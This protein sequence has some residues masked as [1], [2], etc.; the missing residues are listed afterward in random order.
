M[1]KNNKG[2]RPIVAL[3][4]GSGYNEICRIMLS[5][6][7]SVITIHNRGD[8]NKIRNATHL[9]LS[10]GADIH[11]SYYAQET[12]YARGFDVKRDWLELRLARYAINR[13]MPTLGICRG[14]QMLAV[15]DGGA[16]WQDFAIQCEGGTHAPQHEIRTAK[17]SWIREVLGERCIVNSFHHQAVSGISLP[18]SWRATAWSV[19]DKNNEIIEGMEHKSKPVVGVQFHPEYITNDKNKAGEYLLYSWLDG[20]VPATSNPTQA[21]TLPLFA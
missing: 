18:K 17:H 6:G 20:D 9:L 1:A 2:F 21:R 12:S 5:G 15:A 14:M 16:L 3:T 19:G 10:G 13:G 4:I 11:P 7:A 8:L